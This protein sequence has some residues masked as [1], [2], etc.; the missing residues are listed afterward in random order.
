[1]KKFFIYLFCTLGLFSNYLFAIRND[2][3]FDVSPLIQKEKMFSIGLGGIFEEYNSWY[4]NGLLNILDPYN[5]N[6]SRRD[7]YFT[8]APFFNIRPIRFIE[9]GFAASFA[10]RRQ[11]SRNDST[12][13]TN[14]TDSF[15]FK[16]IDANIKITMLDW[17]L[18]LGTKIGASF[19]FQKDS[20][21]Y[22]QRRIKDN[23]NFY[24][25]I[26]IA[27]VPKVIPVN[28]LF[29][30]IFDTRDN[31]LTDI[32]NYGEIVGALEIITSP[33]IT[34]YTGVSYMFPYKKGLEF[35]YTYVEPFVKVK[36]TISDFLYMTASYEKVVWGSGNIPN[37]ATFNFS[38]EY[39]F[40]SP[41]WSWWY[42]GK[43]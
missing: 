18:S 37:T 33:F 20:F 27:G 12:R 31:L 1:M 16:D 22:T 35:D 15:G 11:D 9:L 3:Y 14:K 8:I 5:A 23:F 25:N 42:L 39:M 26:M 32:L 28:I 30:Y 38:I 21:L 34:I 36:A 13:L 10:Y 41:K 29:C 7:I 19:S 17:Y 24:A 2:Y 43:S 40:Y 4:Q 6:I